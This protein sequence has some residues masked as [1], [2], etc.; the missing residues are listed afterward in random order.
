MA[1]Q[2]V[3]AAQPAKAGFNWTATLLFLVVIGLVAWLLMQPKTTQQPGMAGMS[4][5]HGEAAGGGAGMEEMM[6]QIASAKETLK[7]N[8]MDTQALTTLY[9]SFGM[10]GRQDQIRPY[11]DGAIAELTAKKDE[12]GPEAQQIASDIAV[13]AIQG[14]D[15]AGALQALE[16]LHQIAPEKLQVVAMLGDL[17]Y[18]L[19]NT[20]KAI[21]WYDTYLKQ[22]KPESEGEDYWKVCV[23]RA[24]M[25]LS[26]AEQK[27]DSSLTQQAVQELERVTAAQPQMF[28]AWFNL[29]HAYDK[30]GQTERASEIWQKC[31]G[32]AVGDM[33]KWQVDS[34][35]ARLQGKEPPPMPAS[36]HGEGMGMPGGEMA[37][38]HGGMEN[39][40]GATEN[41]HGT[42]DASGT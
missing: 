15:L 41:P 10:I 33:Q 38:P 9:Q 27:K 30:S 13:A 1:V 5:P 19:G 25:L 17:N 7:T 37:N 39:P 4:N 29:G 11:L 24:T 8:P 23:D 18:D 34:Q 22:A 26:A 42:G 21:E 35:L 12:L 16:V 28:N 2:P 31:L 6:A 32:L 40:H 14:Q 20:D 36:P 3:A